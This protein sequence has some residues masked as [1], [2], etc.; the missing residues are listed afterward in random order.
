MLID[1]TVAFRN[2]GESSRRTLTSRPSGVVRSAETSQVVR[3]VVVVI[4]YVID[5][6][7]G[8]AADVVRPRAVT[9]Y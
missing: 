5:L 7:A 4:A 3:L 2:L 8:L 6:G 9:W 1:W